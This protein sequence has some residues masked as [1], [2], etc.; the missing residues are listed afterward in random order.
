[1]NEFEDYYLKGKKCWIC[2]KETESFVM[3]RDNSEEKQGI[4]N[5]TKI[6]LCL[7]HLKQTKNKLFKRK[8]EK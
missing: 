4:T 6:N 3:F 5:E 1:M 2:L 7:S 8:N